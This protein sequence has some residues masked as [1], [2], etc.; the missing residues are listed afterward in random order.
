LTT[1][2]RFKRLDRGLDEEGH[3][4]EAHVVGLLERVLVIGAQVHRR[5]EVDFVEGGQ[6]GGVLLCLE[7]ALG[8][9][10]A[11]PG[12]GYA[13]FLAHVLGPLAIGAAAFRSASSVAFC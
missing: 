9:A 12:H 5:L 2:K 6:N 8:D 7:Q 4:A 1:G 13:L 10:R 11:Q 3:E